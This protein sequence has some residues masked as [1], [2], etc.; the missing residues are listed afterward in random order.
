MLKDKQYLINKWGRYFESPFKPNFDI[1]PGW[2][3]LVDNGLEELRQIDP[4]FKLFQVKQKFGELRIY[5]N[6]Y[7]LLG[8]KIAEIEAQSFNIC[9]YCGS[10]KDVT[11]PTATLSSYWIMTLCNN[12]RNN[13]SED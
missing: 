2:V 1:G 12:C 13:E 7:H 6:N 11:T 4:S 8:D 9:E 10:Q 5:T 3:D